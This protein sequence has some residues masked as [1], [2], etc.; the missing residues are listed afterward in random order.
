MQ[1]NR[2]LMIPALALALAVTG[3][4]SKKGV[5]AAGG[6]TAAAGSS[7][8]ASQTGAGSTTGLGENGGINGQ[9]LNGS[10][11]GAGSAANGAAE[12]DPVRA[13]LLKRVVYFDFDSSDIS[14][15]DEATL[16]AHARYIK[17]NSSAKVTL[18]GHTDERGTREYNMALGERRA[19]AVQS[20]FITNGVSSSQLDTVSY[21]KE[22]PANEG[23]TEAA[24]AENRRVEIKYDAGQP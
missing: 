24:W 7:T 15:D 13:A 18:A 23:H 20:F 19:K 5:V 2:V 4:S 14:A 8:N 17:G 1:A 21:G 16:L 11:S 12:T 22:M 10:T 6:E 3:C 9:G